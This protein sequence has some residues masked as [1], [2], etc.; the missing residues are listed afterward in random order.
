M[1]MKTS[2][3]SAGLV[4]LMS[5]S[6]T[7]SFSAPSSDGPTGILNVPTADTV[8]RGSFEMM[9][10]YD[11]PKVAGMGIG[12]F[13]VVTLGYG[14]QNAEIGLD[15]FNIEGY[16]AV[17]SANAKYVFVHETKEMPAIAAGAMYLRG[18]VAETDVYLVASDSL[19][20]GHEFRATGGL[21]YQKPNNSSSNN[22]TEM[23]GIELGAPGASTTGGLDFV[24][25]DIAAG[26]MIGATLRQRV[27]RNL[28]CQVGYGN[29]DRYFV[30]IIV[31][32]GK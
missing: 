27:T 18:N 16:T 8:E 3:F 32:F 30:G 17:E 25:K 31:K 2:V 4:A 22:F 24:V 6:A 13:P 7:A 23:M 26:D 10:A 5:L 28:A 9:L 20:L 19:G 21:L 15:Y 29:H 14:L 12:V 11:R 1:E